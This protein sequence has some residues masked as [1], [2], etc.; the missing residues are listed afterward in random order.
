MDDK[1]RAAVSLLGGRQSRTERSRAALESFVRGSSWAH[2]VSEDTLDD[3]LAATSVRELTAGEVLCR[4]GEP[5]THW[6]GIMQGLLRQDTLCRDG[7]V[8]SLTA[9]PMGTWFGEA[10]LLLHEARRY[11]ISAMRDSRVA[12]VGAAA[13]RRAFDESAGFNAA[14]SRS[15]SSRLDFYIDLFADQRRLDVER[16]VARIL[17]TL[18]GHDRHGPRLQLDI[19]QDELAG[20]AGVSRQRVSQALH[21]LQ[22]LGLL[23]LAYSSI[24]VLDLAGLGSGC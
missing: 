22:S 9:G 15:L 19:T 13:F 16:R 11:E 23:E 12:C 4:Q 5:A 1:Q 7:T 14:V 2:D 3:L 24:T 20:L 8:T 10:T 17:V 18:V 6:Y 21:E